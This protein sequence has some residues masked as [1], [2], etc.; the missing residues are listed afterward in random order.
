MLKGTTHQLVGILGW[1]LEHTLSP[2]MHNA[3]FRVLGLD[4]TYYAWPVAPDDLAAA[5]GGLRALSAMGA[6]VTMPHK[7]AVVDLLDGVSGDAR[8]IGAVNTI[9]R[10]GPQ[11]V[12]HNTDVDGFREFLDGDAGF[13]AAG[14]RA[15]ILGAGGA[16]RAVVRAL[17]E[18]KTAE[19]IVAARN[20][21]KGALLV[22][23]ASGGRARSV[24]WSEGIETAGEFDLVV[25]ATPLGM[26]TEDRIDSIHLSSTQVVVDLVYHAP[27]TPLLEA[28]REAG[29]QSWPGLGMLVRQAAAS[30]Q[31]WTGQDPPLETMSA[32]AVRA[33]GSAR[34][35]DVQGVQPETP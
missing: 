20:E 3:A 35:S 29:A 19:I 13:K 15:L 11:L 27:T 31:I 7:E 9:Q 30:F 25:N 1:P 28:A 32:V 10:V 2:M 22:P 21:E 4:W 5:V 12:G 16:A 8:M 26:R 33:L 14:K 18:L 34:G 6:N 24:G 17:D 23:L